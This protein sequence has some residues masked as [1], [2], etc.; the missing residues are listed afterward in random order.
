[1]LRASQRSRDVLQFD[2]GGTVIALVVVTLGFASQT[3]GRCWTAAEHRSGENDTA[4]G[5]INAA[6]TTV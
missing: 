5:R 1:M 3:T 4:P 6:S 2:S